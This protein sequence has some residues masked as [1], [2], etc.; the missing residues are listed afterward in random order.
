MKSG[1]YQIINTI[2][3]DLYIGSSIN[4]KYRKNRH[5]KDLRKGNHHSIILQRA[6]NKYG[7][8]NFKFRIIELCEK[9]LLISKEQYYID[10]LKPKYNIYKTAGSPLG[11]KKS[12]ETKEKHRQYAIDNNIKPP[13]STWKDKQ[14]S[15][16]KLDKN[17]LEVLEKYNSLS[18]ACRSVNKDATFT[19]T[20]ASFCNNKR[21]SSYRYRWLFSL[22]DIDKLRNKIPLIA[23]NKG[24]T[25]T[26]DTKPVI[27]Y[28]LKNEYIKEWKSV[29]EA[30]A[31]YG[32]GIGNCVRG[33]SN[34]SNWYKWKYKQYR[35]IIE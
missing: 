32:K 20:I 30:E 9:E 4:L 22:E 26:K 35:E 18:E 33:K 3:N 31:I 15:I 1:I 17:T 19:S 28:S 5:S 6:V 8:T 13:E 10:K 21:F 23:W 24:K 11:N 12:E 2:T 14:K 7:I 27:Q 25:F 34:S 16:Y 29:K